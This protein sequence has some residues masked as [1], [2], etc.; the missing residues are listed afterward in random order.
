[1]PR[2]RKDPVL[3]L[4]RFET[5]A[6]WSVFYDPLYWSWMWKILLFLCILYMR[7]NSSAVHLF[8]RKREVCAQ[9]RL[10]AYTPFHEQACCGPERGIPAVGPPELKISLGSGS[11]NTSCSVYRSLL[12]LKKTVSLQRMTRQRRA[13]MEVLHRRN[14]HPTAEEVHGLVRERAPRI[15]LGTVYRNLEV[16]SSL[17]LVP[18]DRGRGPATALRRKPG[19]PFPFPVQKMRGNARHG[20]PGELDASHVKGLSRIPDHRVPAAVWRLLSEMLPPFRWRHD[21]GI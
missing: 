9:G 19:P 21:Q 16:L 4:E 5:S 18:G 10:E 13:L 8:F 7:I 20:T 14:W 11:G 2:K 1:M 12:K 15:S 17:G 3:P 6:G